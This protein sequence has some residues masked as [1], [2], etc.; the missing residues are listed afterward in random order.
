MIEGDAERER[1]A[2]REARP[3]C[4]V[5][6][7]GALVTE[8]RQGQLGTRRESPVERV[9]VHVVVGNRATVTAKHGHE[10]ARGDVGRI[11]PKTVRLH[12]ADRSSNVASATRSVFRA[13]WRCQ[14]TVP[15]G[16]S[17]ISP[18]S[19]LDRPSMSDSSTM[20]R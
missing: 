14:R 10:V 6:P 2:D 15:R 5:L 19:V 4:R 9:P 18:I 16:R 11:E 3:P 13:W 1:R 12:H 8:T 7:P 20:S 17:S